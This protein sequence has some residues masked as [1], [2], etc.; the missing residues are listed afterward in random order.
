MPKTYDIK[1]LQ[2]PDALADA[3]ATKFVSWENAKT[4]WVA[5]K[6]ETL[7][8]LFATSTRDIYNQP[9]ETDN[10]THIPKLTD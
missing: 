8:N 10:S 1:V 6:K 2:D 4:D 3:I 7:E 9:R 5:D